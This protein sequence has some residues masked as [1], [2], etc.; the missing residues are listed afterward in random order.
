M[1]RRNFVRVMLD[2]INRM[3]SCSPA[4]VHEMLVRSI[5]N[6]HKNP[7]EVDKWIQSINDLHRTQPLP[8]VRFRRL[9]MRGPGV[10]RPPQMSTFVTPHPNSPSLVVLLIY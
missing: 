8:Q 2:A 10:G 1:T 4:R 3:F 7:A 9:I 6:A 5:E